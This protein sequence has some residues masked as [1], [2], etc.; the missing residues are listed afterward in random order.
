VEHVAAA[1]EA[2][3]VVGMDECAGAPERL[4]CARVSASY[5]EMELSGKCRAMQ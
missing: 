1:F 4:V 5:E 2:Q 3:A